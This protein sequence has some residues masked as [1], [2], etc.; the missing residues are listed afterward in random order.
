MNNEIV[1][2]I[3]DNFTVSRDELHELKVAQANHEF[4]PIKQL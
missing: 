1:A 4:R 2:V 3:N